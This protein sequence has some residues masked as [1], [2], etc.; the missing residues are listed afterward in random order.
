VWDRPEANVVLSGMSTLD[1]VKENV[2]LAD[3]AIPNS[4]T[5][6][7]KGLYEKVE[8][9]YRSLVAVD[10]SGCKYCMPCP[11]GVDI[12]GNF[13]MLNNAAMFGKNDVTKMDYK[14]MSQNQRAASCQKCGECEEKCPQQIPIMEKLEEV[15]KILE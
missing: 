9:K 2:R 11:A 13:R 10:C 14:Y 6:K 15:R 8:K 5:K 1:Q 12:P 4:L 3:S 7:E